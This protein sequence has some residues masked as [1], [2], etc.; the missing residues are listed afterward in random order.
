MGK[1]K[2]KEE[3]E[4]ERGGKKRS[5]KTENRDGEGRKGGWE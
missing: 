3:G 5:K 1:R 2:R 4:W